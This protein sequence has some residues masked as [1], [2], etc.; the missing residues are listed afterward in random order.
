MNASDLDAFSFIPRGH[1]VIGIKAHALLMA[2]TRMLGWL[3]ETGNCKRWEL[4]GSTGS[5]FSGEAV[6]SYGLPQHWCASF[7]HCHWLI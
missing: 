3:A 1:K 7:S 6:Q 5:S 4:A 2:S